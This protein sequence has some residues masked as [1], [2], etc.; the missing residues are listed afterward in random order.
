MHPDMT[1]A[2]DIP[3]PQGARSLVPWLLVAAVPMIFALVT[4]QTSWSHSPVRDW[5]RQFGI[6][7]VAGEICVIGWAMLR[8]AAPLGIIAAQPRWVGACLVGL[9]AIAFATALLAAPDQVRALSWTFLWLVHLAFGLAVCGLV[10]S[11]EEWSKSA[12]WPA[13]VAGLCIY[14]LLVVTFVHSVPDGRPFN[15]ERFP[16][17]GG[18]IRHIGHFSTIGAAA[19]AGS[20][21]FHRGW[22]RYAY[23]LAAAVMLSL[24]FWS[25]TR[26]S[27]VA[28][29][30]AFVAGTVMIARLRSIGPWLALAASTAAGALLSLAGPTPNSL[31][32]MRRLAATLDAPTADALASGRLAMWADAW[33]AFLRQ[34]WFGYGQGQ[35]PAV[36]ESQ[37]LFNQPHNILLQLLLQWGV[38]GTAL[39]LALA[40]YVAW[41][42]RNAL[43]SQSG[44]QAPAFLVAAAIFVMSL[45]DAT[46][47]HSYPTMMFAFSLAVLVGARDQRVRT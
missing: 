43:R 13:V 5:L 12:I 15:W 4:W 18:N 47:F 3:A 36:V 21:A 23:W 2:R 34:P 28:L 29:W 26:G 14:A 22:A 41:Q 20:A 40:A 8:G 19:A 42:C 9:I 27:I 6:P 46:L 7:A 45:Y 30:A 35:F 33:A 32:G 11:A 24:S 38:I 16:L 31:F 37:R 10:R 25:G 1:A 17:A 39:A 44:I